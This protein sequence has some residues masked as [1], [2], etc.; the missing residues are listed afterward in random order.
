MLL[1][2]SIT[3]GILQIIS[4]LLKNYGLFW[5]REPECFSP[6]TQNCRNIFAKFIN[7]HNDI[8]KC[9]IISSANAHSLL[10]GAVVM[11]ADVCQKAA[12]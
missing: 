3:H 6:P 10:L 11:N 8:C 2:L 9:V 4:V 1:P 12:V 5:Q 7:L